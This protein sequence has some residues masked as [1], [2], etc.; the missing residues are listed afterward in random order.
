RTG[1]WQL[2]CRRRRRAFPHNSPAGC[3]QLKVWRAPA[4]DESGSDDVLDLVLERR[5]EGA[6]SA[7]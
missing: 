7:G 1:R 2:L 4:M 3:A 6:S 5:N